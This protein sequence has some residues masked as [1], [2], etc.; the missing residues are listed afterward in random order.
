VYGDGA[1]KYSAVVRGGR[2]TVELH[3]RPV[4]VLGD[5]PQTIAH[6]NGELVEP[7]RRVIEPNAQ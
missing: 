5:R 4:A 6:A 2:P 7:R 1:A 3:E